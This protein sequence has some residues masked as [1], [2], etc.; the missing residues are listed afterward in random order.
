MALPNHFNVLRLACSE[1]I[2]PLNVQ[3]LPSEKRHFEIRIGPVIS[4]PE[5][6]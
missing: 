6:T 3:N 1:Q 5:N 2:N 4:P